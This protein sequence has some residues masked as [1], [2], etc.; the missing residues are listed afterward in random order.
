M[1]DDVARVLSW[2]GEHGS[3]EALSGMAQYGIPDERAFGDT[4]S[5]S[6]NR[7]E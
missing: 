4:R 5:G 3:G 2:L 6:S 7:V 1:K